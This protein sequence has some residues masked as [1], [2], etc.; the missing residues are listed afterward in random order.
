MIQVPRLHYV[1]GA[2]QTTPDIY[3][4]T[5]RIQ[6][7]HYSGESCFYEWTITLTL[8]GRARLHFLDSENLS[9]A[10]GTLVLTRPRSWHVWNVPS[11][12]NQVDGSHV[13]ASA[14][15]LVYAVFNPRPHWTKWL[16][17]IQYSNG[18]A[19]WQFDGKACIE[20]ERVMLN[21]ARTYAK[22]SLLRDDRT[23]AILELALITAERS[24][25]LRIVP[26]PRIRE[27]VDSIHEGFAEPLSVADLAAAIHLSTPYFAARF[28]EY[29]GVPPG[30]YIEQIRLDRAAEKLRYGT[31]GI[32]DIARAVGYSEAKYFTHRFRLRYGLTP[33]EFRLLNRGAMGRAPG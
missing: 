25:R 12:V 10:R 13:E 26:D 14:W 8:G 32:G 27:S 20:L 2:T 11:T 6:A 9:V 23:M 16:D 24:E 7:G 29:V 22:N 28:T 33:R 31:E 18:I 19:L 4:D 15:E 5:T 3:A 21:I 1:P 30:Q 17:C